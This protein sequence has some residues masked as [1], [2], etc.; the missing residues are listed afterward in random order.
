MSILAVQYLEGG[1]NFAPPGV[2]EVRAQLR[3]AFALLPITDLLIGWDVPPELARVCR[4]ECERAGVR[5]YQWHPLLVGWGDVP[6]RTAWQV[7]GP[8]GEPLAGFE[9][10]PEFTFLRLDDP[11]VQAAV[12][13]RLEQVVRSG[14]YDGVFLDRIRY[15]A[16]WAYAHGRL[17]EA[18]HVTRL[19]MRAAEVIRA[20]GLAVGL[21][22][23]AP[24]LAPL[25]GQD[26]GALAAVSDWVKVMVYGHTWAPAGMPFELERLGKF[27]TGHA[28]SAEHF[29]EDLSSAF[30]ALSAVN[31]EVGLPPEVLAAEV[32]LG[33][34]MGVEVLLAGVELVEVEGVTRLSPAQVRAD[35]AALRKAG[36]DGW[37][38]SWDLRDMPRDHLRVVGEFL[39]KEVSGGRGG[40]GCSEALGA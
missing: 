17:P 33:R 21:D 26:L 15:P 36:V 32:H 19:V 27:V 30:A 11:A 37:V 10:L 14:L 9:G 6:L 4:G 31:A 40:I 12:L 28:E 7:V 24:S 25:V 35:L 38:L 22:C 29:R 39:A 20:E 1:S 8:D 2:G 5:L 18:E 16:E 34:E 13:G 3:E 23:F